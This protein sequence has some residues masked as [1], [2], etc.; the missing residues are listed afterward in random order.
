MPLI[1]A[2]QQRNLVIE[3]V[4]GKDEVRRHLQSLGIVTGAPIQL[5]G[6]GSSGVIC[7]VAGCRLALDRKTASKISVAIA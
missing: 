6:I 3:S 4:R 1:V 7:D 2:P 5:S